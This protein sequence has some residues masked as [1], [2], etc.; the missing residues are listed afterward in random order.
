MAESISKPGH[1]CRIRTH[2]ARVATASL[3][4]RPSRVSLERYRRVELRLP[5]W[6]AVTRRRVYR[7]NLVEMVGIE[8][9]RFRLQGGCSPELSYIPMRMMTVCNRHSYGATGMDSNPRPVPYRGT[10]L[11]N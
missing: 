11:P 7:V 3:A 4:S 9:T 10:A 1:D 2:V 6:K 5:A 8:P